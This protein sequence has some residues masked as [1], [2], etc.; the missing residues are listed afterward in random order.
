MT[1]DLA[2]TRQ[3]I[4]AKDRSLPG[5]V[6]GR[7]RRAIDLM[8]W[9]AA[10]RKQAAERCGMS[11]HSMRQA[12]RRPHVIRYYRELCV[13]LRESGR[14]KRIHRLDEIAAQDVNRNAAVQAIKA[15]EQLDEADAARGVSGVPQQP[16]IVIQ[17]ISSA[18]GVKV[19]PT[20]EHDDK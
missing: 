16:G 4:A 14:A 10:S 11:D 17:I 15:A 18:D 2:P 7:L 1:N 12:L 5:R 6:T 20:I 8:V 19:G 13:V 3:A 9:E